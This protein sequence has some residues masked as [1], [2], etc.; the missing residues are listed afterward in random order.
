MEYTLVYM[1][2]PEGSF[3]G[4]LAEMPE[5]IAQ[6][7]SLDDLESEIATSMRVLLEYKRDEES[8]REQLAPWEVAQKK[9]IKL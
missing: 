2:G 3:T 1:E 7:N 5:V 9:T 6:A 4:Y 8:R